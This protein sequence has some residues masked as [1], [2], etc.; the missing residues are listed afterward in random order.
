MGRDVKRSRVFKFLHRSAQSAQEIQV[1]NDFCI[2]GNCDNDC[3][4]EGTIY[5]IWVGDNRLHCDF[6]HEY[7]YGE[8]FIVADCVEPGFDDFFVVSKLSN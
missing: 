7:G 5:S 8:S 3:F 6:A 2:S 4:G 1:F